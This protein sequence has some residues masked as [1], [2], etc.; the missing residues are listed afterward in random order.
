M[1]SGEDNEKP[2][3]VE[4]DVH[5]LT[6]KTKGTGTVRS[7]TEK[8]GE[9]VIKG[10]YLLNVSSDIY[11]NSLEPSQLLTDQKGQMEDLWTVTQVKCVCFCLFLK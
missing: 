1:M 4:T 6:C 2:R 9:E 7:R 3:R 11:A 10:S 8:A 5:A